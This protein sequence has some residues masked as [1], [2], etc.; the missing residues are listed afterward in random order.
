MHS[1]DHRDR[2]C[3]AALVVFAQNQIAVLALGTMHGS[4]ITAL[5]LHPIGAVV[6]PAAIGVLHHH[7]AAGP[8]EVAAVLFVPLRRRDAVQIDLVAAVDVF[9]DG[10]T[11]HRPGR[12]GL[13]LAHVASPECDKL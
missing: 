13:H 11:F 12:Y 6:D 1:N 4:D 2:A 7:H 3:L 8:D 9:L 5:D 10:S